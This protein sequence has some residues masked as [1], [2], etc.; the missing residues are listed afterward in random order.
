MCA[1]VTVENNRS[2]DKVEIGVGPVE[3]PGLTGTIF[4]VGPDPTRRVFA[5]D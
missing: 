2:L 3:Y 4:R 1:I 5:F